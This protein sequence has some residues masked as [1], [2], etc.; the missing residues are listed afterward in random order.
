[1]HLNLK[2][3]NTDEHKRTNLK[4]ITYLFTKVVKIEKSGTSFNLCLDHCGWSHL[5]KEW[6]GSSNRKPFQN[7]KV[8]EAEF[9]VTCNQISK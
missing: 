9:Q 3:K 8:I 2:G 7:D 4:K 5:Q 6:T 1:M